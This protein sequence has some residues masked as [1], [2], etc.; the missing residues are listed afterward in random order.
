MKST[1]KKCWICLLMMV[2]LLKKYNGFAKST[3]DQVT[4][5]TGK[6]YLLFL[7]KIGLSIKILA[8][9]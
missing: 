6:Y 4:C 3:D 1:V 8:T 5:K 9:A 7:L 2:F